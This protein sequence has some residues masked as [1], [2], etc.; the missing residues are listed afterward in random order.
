MSTPV[1]YRLEAELHR[2]ELVQDVERER[3]ARL[4]SQQRKGSILDDVLSSLGDLLI[5]LG[6][7]L[8]QQYFVDPVPKWHM[9]GN[10]P[11]KTRIIKM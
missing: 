3:L 11:T 10:T 7:S 1:L 5:S 6:N 9:P 2:R 4:A 8:K